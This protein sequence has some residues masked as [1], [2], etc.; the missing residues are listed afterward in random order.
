ML[1]LHEFRARWAA[2]KLPGIEEVVAKFLVT[3]EVHDA[4]AMKVTS[5]DLDYL[6]NVANLDSTFILM[7]FIVL[8]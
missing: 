3:D 8:H 6:F 5:A 2:L 1:T 7:C 4:N